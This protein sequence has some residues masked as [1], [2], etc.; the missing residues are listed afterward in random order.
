MQSCKE[1]VVQFANTCDPDL[2][3]EEDFANISFKNVTCELDN[4]GGSCPGG[5]SMIE[6]IDGVSYCTFQ[7][8]LCVTCELVST[9]VNQDFIRKDIYVRVQTNNMP[10]HCY[11]HETAPQ[12]QMIDF[13]VK[14]NSVKDASTLNTDIDRQI[15]VDFRLC[16][17]ETFLEEMIPKSAKFIAIQGQDLLEKATGIALNGVLIYTSI[18]RETL[19]DP[20]SVV[21]QK[22]TKLS[23]ADQCLGYIDYDNTSN[24]AY[25]YQSIPVCGSVT[26]NQDILRIGK[27]CKDFTQCWQN[28]VSYAFQ[29]SLT[30]NEFE[31]MG[32]IKDGNIL[33]GLFE[34]LFDENFSISEEDPNQLDVC[35]GIFIGT[36]Y[37]YAMTSYYPYQPGCFGPG[38]IKKITPKCTSNLRLKGIQIA[39]RF[40]NIVILVLISTIYLSF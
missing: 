38:N 11:Y 34:A 16:R 1:F 15:E 6:N 32:L 10:N 20:L 9:Y 25:Y 31:V 33:Y 27:K 21:Y 29:N 30:A 18:Q 12:P 19:Q 28:P 4:L 8:Q 17:T 2:P 36:Q 7:R 23:E 40:V 3:V 22:V 26:T 39:F 24:P 35:N 14:W 37:A 13:K 5:Q